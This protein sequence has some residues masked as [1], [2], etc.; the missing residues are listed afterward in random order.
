[1]YGKGRDVVGAVMSGGPPRVKE[2]K[3]RTEINNRKW[4]GKREGRG[5]ACARGEKGRGKC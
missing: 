5:F 3:G 2:G 4:E 1:M